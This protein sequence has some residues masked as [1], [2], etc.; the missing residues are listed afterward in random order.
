M[1]DVA[2]IGTIGQM[3]E[4]SEV[5]FSILLSCDHI[6]LSH[7]TFGLWAALLSSEDK[8]HIMP[9]NSKLE[10]VENLSS[11]HMKNI[12]MINDEEN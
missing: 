5:D 8:I 1:I 12:L 6:I 4:S 2:F 9:N 10:E 11:L 3:K 7:G